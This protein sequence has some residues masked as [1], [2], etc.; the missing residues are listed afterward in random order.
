MASLIRLAAAAGCRL[1]LAVGIMGT[2]DHGSLAGWPGLIHVVVDIEIP[3]PASEDKPHSANT[4]Q[5]SFG[6]TFIIVPLAK[7]IHMV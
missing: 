7:A 2:M 1:M 5:V 4:L 3:G 6:V